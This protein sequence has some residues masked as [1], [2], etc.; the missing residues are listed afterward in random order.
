[1]R[2]DR[3]LI[4]DYFMQ[5]AERI[6]GDAAAT[7]RERGAATLARWVFRER[8]TEIHVRRL[9]REEQLPGRRSAEQIRH[10][11]E[12]LVEATLHNERFRPLVF[13]LIGHPGRM[14]GSG[15][16]GNDEP[17]ACLLSGQEA[18]AR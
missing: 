2:R 5:M 17:A 16:R 4:S 14:P 1:M 18:A 10:A 11:A 8:P 9:Q 7:E 15:S 13:C 3:L 6:Y 12:V